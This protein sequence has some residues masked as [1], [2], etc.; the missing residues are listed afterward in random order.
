MSLKTKVQNKLCN[1]KNG[2]YKILSQ[3]IRS[4]N[5][6]FKEEIE[7]STE[8]LNELK[9]TITDRVR[10][11]L[12]EKQEVNR[13]GHCDTPIL[14]SHKV[15]CS[16]KCSNNSEQTKNK[17][18][19]RYDSLS[20]KEKQERNQKRTETVKERYGGYT[21]ENTELVKKVRTTMVERYGV[22]HP[23]QSSILR[24]KA[25]GTWMSKYGT[26]N[27]FKSNLI[28]DKI[29]DV[30]SKKYGVTNAANVDSEKRIG[31]AMKTKIE[32]GWVIPDEFLSDYQLYRKKVKRLTEKTYEEHKNKINPNNFE[33]V[34]NGKSGYQLDHKYSILEGFLNDIEPE[35]ISHHCNLQMLE[36]EI[37]RAKSKRC[38][39][40]LQELIK[41]I[42]S[43]E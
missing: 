11:V 31:N 17:F 24:N 3:K 22:E 29:V 7:L 4:I 28:K 34:T 13:C 27:P 32:R 21:L 36:W 41:E 18:R 43:Y 26:D 15:Y 20:K 16:K 25:I 42:K 23:F 1:L 37:N 30:L 35:T 19:E 9:P 2:E 8:F 12:Q 14:S 39:I 38:D 10:Y 6:L 5:I 40:E 33:R